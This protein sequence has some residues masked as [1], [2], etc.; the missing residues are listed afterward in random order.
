MS[1]I[2]YICDRKA[3][4]VCN[5]ICHHTTDITHAKNFIKNTIPTDPIEYDYW[6]TNEASIYEM[7]ENNDD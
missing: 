7:G 1:E 6:E 2:F 5:D 4:E 3:C